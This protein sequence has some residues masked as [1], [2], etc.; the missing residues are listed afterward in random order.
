MPMKYLILFL[1]AVSWQAMAIDYYIPHNRLINPLV[2]YEC[3]SS[4][5]CAKIHRLPQGTRMGESDQKPSPDSAWMYVR[6][7]KGKD[8]GFVYRGSIMPIQKPL[9]RMQL[10]ATQE[11]KAYTQ[12]NVLY[13]SVFGFCYRIPPEL[14]NELPKTKESAVTLKKFIIDRGGLT[15]LTREQLAGCL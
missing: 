2:V 12:D 9:T 3:E 7:H 1:I 14:I 11:I 8:S 4:S 6:F 10:I 15:N 5:K 13:V